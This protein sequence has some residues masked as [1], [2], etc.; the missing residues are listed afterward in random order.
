MT[1]D[2]AVVLTLKVNAGIY[3]ICLSAYDFHLINAKYIYFSDVLVKITVHYMCVSDNIS[4]TLHAFLINS[5][6][7]IYKCDTQ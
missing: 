6:V 1:F 2:C 7:I 3:I 4:G 5:Y